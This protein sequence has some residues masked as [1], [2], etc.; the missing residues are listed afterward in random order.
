M[1]FSRS[2]TAP[3][4]D[5]A[6]R[7]AHWIAV[8]IG[9]LVSLQ[10][11]QVGSQALVP[12]RDRGPLQSTERVQQPAMTQT[13]VATLVAKS[14]D[15]PGNGGSVDPLSA[16]QLPA[17]FLQGDTVKCGAPALI[18]GYYNMSDGLLAGY[19]SSRVSGHRQSSS[20]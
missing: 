8:W 10:A 7:A 1:S 4:S 17:N 13:D 6:R 15:R 18:I 20:C 9:A 14:V 11:T 2:S 12:N 5:I 16:N 19:Q 3:R